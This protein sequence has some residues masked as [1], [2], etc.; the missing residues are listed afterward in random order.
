MQIIVGD[1]YAGLPEYKRDV[2]ALGIVRDVCRARPKGYEHTFKYKRGFWD[3][4][5]SLMH[6]IYQF[7]SGLTYM[8][9]DAL[10][11]AGY[12]IE[13][14]AKRKLEYTKI[15]PDSLSGVTLRDYQ[16]EAVHA[17][18][19]RGRGVAQMATNSGKTEVMAGIIKALNVP[20][21]VVLTMSREILYQTA[22]RFR[23][24]LGIECGLIGDGLLSRKQVTIAMV[25]SLQS[26][27]D[28][29]GFDQNVLLM[30]DECHHV[31]S[32]T[33]MDV[34]AHIPGRCRFGFS[35][36]PLKGDLLSDL[37]LIGY[38]GPVA[39]EVS[40]EYMIQQGFSAPTT[41]NF[42][43]VESKSDEEYDM[44][45]RD[46][47]DA[48]I[49][50][51]KIRNDRIVDI[52][53]KAKGTTLILVQRL[54][55]GRSLQKRIKGSKFMHGAIP[56]DMRRAAITGMKKRGGVYIATPIFDEGV[57][58][59]S[60]NTLILACGGESKVK[61]LQ[62]VGRGLR[63]KDGGGTLQVYDFIDD[64]NKYLLD[65]AAKRMDTYEREGFTTNVIR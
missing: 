54:D 19:D 1:V 39:Y 35:G 15:Q 12:T 9:R 46:A 43:I 30:V 2:R 55:H 4:Y 27:V 59:P 22:E 21:T 50:N 38:T 34:M 14:R 58:I 53:K 33:M 18:L 60:I 49:V 26:I 57:D 5:V 56:T 40:N 64:T 6:N 31:S 65:H 48:L 28:H 37:K 24:R 29:L 45:Y 44:R 13:V 63:L 51:N 16:V 36:T 17:L 47:Y 42:V 23:N 25:Q 62:R 8:V 20:P 61:L 41:I 7:P 10:V 11:S 3:G 52:A 32:A